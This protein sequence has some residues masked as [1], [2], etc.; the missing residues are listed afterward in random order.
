MKNLAIVIAACAALCTVT[1]CHH[2]RHHSDPGHGREEMRGRPDSH[3]AKPA[4]K[5]AEKGPNG[6][7]APA[8]A[9]HGGKDGPKH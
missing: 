4:P 8:P 6:H 3:H 9:P 2:Y 7:P 5:H 1:G